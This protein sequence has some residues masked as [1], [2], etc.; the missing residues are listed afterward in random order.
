MPSAAAPGLSVKTPDGSLAT[1]RSDG[2]LRLAYDVTK[3][4]SYAGYYSL[5]PQADLSP[6]GAV[7]FLVKGAG[8]GETARAG[9]RNAANAETKIA[10]GQYLPQGVTTAWQRVTMPLAAFHEAARSVGHG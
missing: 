8:G 5:I 4:A 6:Y 2:A 9:L 7:T 10:I 3:T 1:Y